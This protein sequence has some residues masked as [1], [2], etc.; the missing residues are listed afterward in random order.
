MVRLLFAIV[1]VLGYQHSTFVIGCTP[2]TEPP[3]HPVPVSGRKVCA[4]KPTEGK[5]WA[6]EE[7]YLA[8]PTV[9]C[10]K[11]D[12]ITCGNMA[13]DNIRSVFYSFGPDIADA[14]RFR[15]TL[16]PQGVTY[17]DVLD[18]EYFET[19]LLPFGWKQYQEREQFLVQLISEAMASLSHGE[20]YLPILHYQGDEGGV[21]AYQNPLPDDWRTNIWKTN[22]FPTLQRN[23]EVPKIITIDISN[24]DNPI[25]DRVHATD[26]TTDHPYLPPS[27][28][29]NET[30]PPLEVEILEIPAP[31]G[32]RLAKRASAQSMITV[33]STCGMTPTFATVSAIPAT[34]SPSANPATKSPSTAPTTKLPPTTSAPSVSTC[35]GGAICSSAA[36]GTV[37]IEAGSSAVHVGTLTGPA[38]FTSVSSAL[39]KLCPHVTQTTSPT[40]SETGGVNIGHVEYIDSGALQHSG[41]LVVKAESSSYHLNTMREALIVTAAHTAGKGS[42]ANHSCYN[43]TYETVA[44]RDVPSSWLMNVADR[45]AG[46]KRPEPEPIAHEAFMCSTAAF[47]GV[48]YFNPKWRQAATV[49]PQAWLD[50][51]WNF[52][53][54]PAGKWECNFMAALDEVMV[55]VAPEFAPAEAGTVPEIEAICKGIID[56]GA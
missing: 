14:Y 53:I 18:R 24:H 55:I 22:E 29:E 56:H 12:I 13:A 44:K 50:A 33:T 38:L 5:Q 21:G 48:S 49:G 51:N 35:A 6:C 9:A 34:K 36:G 17:Q 11:A 52:H 47:A 3:R 27:N 37:L 19:V 2:N 54:P 46:Y 1:A 16:T 41:Q 26:P 43:Q 30:A 20:A 15:D 40:V 32:R 39:D 8:F 28:I 10:L 7:P 23:D 31:G 45:L 42:V 4:G 25:V